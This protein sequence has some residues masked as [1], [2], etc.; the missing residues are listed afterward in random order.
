MKAM[1]LAAGEGRRMRPLTAKQPKP[2]LSVGGRPLIEHHILN[3]KAAGFDELI[4]NVSYLGEQIADFCGDGIQWGV[5]ITLSHEDQPLE[6]AGGIV[7][8]L[9]WLSSGPFLV[10]NGDVYTDYPFALLRNR[11]LGEAS[12]HLVLV[13]N[14]P[15]HVL[16]DFLLDY[17]SARI[18]QPDRETDKIDSALTFSGIALYHPAFFAGL[19]PD[20]LP[21]KP[22]LDCAITQGRLTGEH[23][24]GVWMDVGTPERLEALNH[25]LVTQ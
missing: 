1:I 11:Q 24:Q 17:D 14:P 21:L 8:A 6:T 18:G 15:H 16:G 13:D 2:L 23:F 9:Q 22:L 19:S 20:K 4:I 5:S 7:K 3:L 12:A 25:Q 10:V